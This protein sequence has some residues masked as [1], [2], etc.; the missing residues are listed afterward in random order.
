M[1]VYERA[2]RFD[3]VDRAGIVYFPRYLGYAHEAMEHFFDGLHGGYPRLIVER[4]IGLPAVDVRASYTAPLRY[5]DTFVIEITTARIGARSAVL[6]YRV[7]R[8]ADGVQA[9]DILHTVVTTDLAAMR[10]V[11][12]P[13]DVRAI[14][15]LHRAADAAPH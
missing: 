10:S 1:I 4:G 5:G 8:R 3:E 12:M 9:A 13:D 14:F 11:D 15:E 6:H 7:L 2:V